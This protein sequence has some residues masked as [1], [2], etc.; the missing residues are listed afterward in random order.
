VTGTPDPGA[1]RRFAERAHEGQR[2]GDGPYTTHLDDVANVLADHGCDEAVV[3]AGYLHDVLEDTQV[4]PEELEAAFGPRV[5]RAVELVTDK[6][7]RNRRERH[8]ATYPAIATAA[9]SG[10]HDA[11]EVKVADRI[12]NLRR[13]L[14]GDAGRLRMYLKEHD[15][16]REL[17]RR[18][19]VADGLWAT[20]D[21]LV[22]EARTRGPRPR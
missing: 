17:L 13:S 22:A 3:S 14:A 8:E 2:Y 16:F 10:Q 19:G 15:R 11:T 9:A 4:T 6:P 20:L 7:G 21:A 18:P 1:A 5:R 12:A